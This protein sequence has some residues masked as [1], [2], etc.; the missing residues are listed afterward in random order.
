MAEIRE[1][2]NVTYRVYDYDRVDKN[3]KKCEL[4]FDKAVQVLNMKAASDV[5]QKPRSVKYYVDTP[6]NCS[7][8]A[9][10]L[11][12]NGFRSQRVLLFL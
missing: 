7:A 10:I 12:R 2:P 6:V 11:K 4:N 3:V 5:S 9:S 1:S 8:A